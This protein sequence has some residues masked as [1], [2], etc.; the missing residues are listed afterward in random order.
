MNVNAMLPAS[1]ALLLID[2]QQGFE[3]PYWGPRNNPEA[4]ANMARLLETWRAEK[5][6]VVHIQHCSIEPDSALRPGQP[7]HNFQSFAEP[8]LGEPVFQKHV[9]SGFIGTGLEAFLREQGWTTLVLVGLTTNHCVSTTARMAGNLGFKAYVVDDATATFD[10]AD[11][12]GR[13]YPAE[14]VHALALASL[15]GEFAT[16]VETA[17][18]LAMLGSVGATAP[19]AN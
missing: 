15:H 3:A 8:I 5:R 1:T 14:Q 12:H 4:E 9:N 7:G 6:P 17:D 19:H 18:V 10:R 11:H 13:V 2:I 16:V